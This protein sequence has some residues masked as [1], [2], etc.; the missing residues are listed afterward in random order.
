MG[1]K[2]LRTSDLDEPCLAKKLQQDW[3]L[4]TAVIY[5]FPQNKSE[6]FKQNWRGFKVGTYQ[7]GNSSEWKLCETM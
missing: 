4:V 7:G 2:R 5:M 6:K 3:K 1:Q